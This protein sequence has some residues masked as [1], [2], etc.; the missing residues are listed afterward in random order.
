MEHVISLSNRVEV[1]RGTDPA[2][3]P[4]YFT[5]WSES[6]ELSETYK[7][8]RDGVLLNQMLDVD[9]FVSFSHDNFLISPRQMVHRTYDRKRTSPKKGREAAEKF[10]SM[11]PEPA[12]MIRVRD[13]FGD[14]VKLKAMH[15]L[16]SEMG[17]KGITIMERGSRTYAVLV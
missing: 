14:D 8:Y 12:K 13:Y 1:Y 7:K 17:R 15:F 3:K 5:W 9:D 11:W 16:F 2:Y 4:K 6:K 10:E